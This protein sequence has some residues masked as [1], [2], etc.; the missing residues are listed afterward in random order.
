MISIVA[1]FKVNKG[2]E[3]K[4][5]SLTEKLGKASRAETGC[6][7]YVLHKH[8]TKKQTYCMLEKWQNQAAIDEHNNSRHFT[9]IVPLLTEIAKV[10]I[11]IY[12]PV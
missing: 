12:R 3:E 5:L 1:K 6:I 11:D 9:E 2:E 10:K 4:F 7:E 8:T